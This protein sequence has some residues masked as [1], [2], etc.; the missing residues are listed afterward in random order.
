MVRVTTQLLSKVRWGQCTPEVLSELRGCGSK[1]P[2]SGGGRG[3]GGGGGGG[4]GETG[5]GDGI[6]VTQLLTHKADVLRVNE[7]VSIFAIY[8]WGL[9]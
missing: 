2:R 5:D 9:W 4:G 7:E 6:E 8:N 3:G 1:L